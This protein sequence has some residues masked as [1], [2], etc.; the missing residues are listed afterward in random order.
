MEI[1]K[2]DKKVL[3]HLS[4]GHMVT[5]IIQG[6]VR[7]LRQQYPS[8]RLASYHELMGFHLEKNKKRWFAKTVK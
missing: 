1:K 4:L 6:G 8:L 2:M 3:S 7:P 5:D